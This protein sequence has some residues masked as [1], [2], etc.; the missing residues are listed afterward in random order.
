[1]K[2]IWVLSAALSTGPLVAAAAEGQANPKFE[3]S[4]VV[5]Q[6]DGI[7]WAL[8]AEPQLT[9]GKVRMLSPGGTIG[10]YTLVEVARDHIVLKGQAET[11]KVR[12]SWR[13][14]GAGDVAS[15]GARVPS[16]RPGAG[17]SAGAQA[18]DGS[19]PRPEVAPAAVV[20]GAAAARE[21]AET[22]KVAQSEGDGAVQPVAGASDNPAPRE[23]VG[24]VAEAPRSGAAAIVPNPVR[25]EE[26]R[27]ARD[28]M[29]RREL[30]IDGY[31]SEKK[32]PDPSPTAK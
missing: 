4:G 30:S 23:P 31:F 16:S 28:A 5:I 29:F 2:A 11:L 7:A 21:P 10:S 19:R 6:E 18:P 20:G 1:M 15:A 27:R 22:P 12:F 25:G 32:K 17:V 9:Q 26:V 24:T 13:S 8:V 14:G 3:V